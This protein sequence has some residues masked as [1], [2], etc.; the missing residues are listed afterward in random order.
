MRSHFYVKLHIYNGT[1]L[2]L[3]AVYSVVLAKITLQRS[4]ND[5]LQA[6]NKAKGRLTNYFNVD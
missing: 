6:R 5:V 2:K 3:T 4:T 1:I